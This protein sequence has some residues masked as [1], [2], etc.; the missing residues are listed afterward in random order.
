MGVPGVTVP[1]FGVPA[2]E[3][4]L[5]GGGVEEEE[6]LVAVRLIPPGPAG[7]RLE[8]LEGVV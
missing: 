2:P 5:S 8:G 4:L 7:G 6:G 1:I 3:V